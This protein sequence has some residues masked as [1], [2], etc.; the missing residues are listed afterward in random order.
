MRNFVFSK[1]DSFFP[2]E[3]PIYLQSVIIHSA[4]GEL[5]KIEFRRSPP[6]MLFK[7]LDVFLDFDGKLQQK[8]NI[9]IFC[10]SPIIAT[11]G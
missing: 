3:D 9:T 1:T 2:Q 6:S 8:E 11:E 4:N 7:S 10:T 5:Q